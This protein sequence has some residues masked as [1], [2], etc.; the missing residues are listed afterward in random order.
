MHKDMQIKAYI[1]CCWHSFLKKNN[2]TVFYT[3]FKLKKGQGKES[4]FEKIYSSAVSSM[5]QTIESFFNWIQVK[6]SIH[7]DSMVRSTDG[8]LASIFARI[9]VAAFLLYS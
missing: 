5:R 1:D 2:N 8:L 4:Y 3:P 9:A 7:A 6:I